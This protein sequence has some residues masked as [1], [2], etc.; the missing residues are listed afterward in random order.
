[1]L[2]RTWIVALVVGLLIASGT[3]I[4]VLWISR[5]PP[6]PLIRT[7]PAIQWTSERPWFPNYSSAIQIQSSTSSN[8]SD[9]EIQTALTFQVVDAWPPLLDGIVY[10][11]IR[12]FVNLST[13]LLQG[14]GS[15]TTFRMATD[16]GS[17]GF[18]YLE[19]ANITSVGYDAPTRTSFLVLRSSTAPLSIWWHLGGTRQALP[20]LQGSVEVGYMVSG[21]PRIVM[22]P[23]QFA[24]GDDSSPQASLSVTLPFTSNAFIGD[25][26][27]VDLYRFSVTNVGS[28][29]V[30]VSH[31]WVYNT[32]IKVTLVGP[33]GPVVSKTFTAI[34]PDS[35]FNITHAL[36]T[37]G[38]YAIEVAAAYP[39]FYQLDCATLP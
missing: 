22:F 27:T 26:D 16:A 37:S 3:A 24:L 36:P 32:S 15:G 4:G 33:Q 28:L 35:G 1:M 14:T 12:I 10:D 2:R 31:L 5:P 34:P 29:Q 7:A 6:I 20:K 23:V 25:W 17:V 30:N 21:S 18:D 9:G 39:M 38:D 19:P 8:Y 11:E 13:R